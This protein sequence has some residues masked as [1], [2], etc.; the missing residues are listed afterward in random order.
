MSDTFKKFNC[1]LCLRDSLAA[2]SIFIQ[3]QCELKERIGLTLNVSDLARDVESL[4]QHFDRPSNIA[5]A[6]KDL[7]EMGHGLAFT[8]PV[9]DLDRELEFLFEKLFSDIGI[10]LEVISE[11]HS[12]EGVRLIAPVTEF[13]RDRKCL[14]EEWDC[15][16]FLIE[17]QISVPEVA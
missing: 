10:F 4:L 5:S 9:T 6:D 3:R 1:R 7:T 14:L 12:T 15:P 11:P 2:V 8:A 17:A 16:L 13:T